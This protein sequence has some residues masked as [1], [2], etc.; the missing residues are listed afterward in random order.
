[1]VGIVL[2]GQTRPTRFATTSLVT[3]RPSSVATTESAS[4]SYGGAT[5]TTTAGTIPMSPP[6]SAGTGIAQSVGDGVLDMLTTGEIH[7]LLLLRH[8]FF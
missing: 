2:M 7:H 1:M 8:N 6:T 5:S 3:P 4:P